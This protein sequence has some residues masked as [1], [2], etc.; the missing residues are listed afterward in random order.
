MSHTRKKDNRIEALH[1]GDVY[2]NEVS[3][4]FSVNLNPLEIPDQVK[5][6]CLHALSELRRY[7]DPHHHDL[8][9]AIADMDGVSMDAVICGNGA[10]ELIMAAVHAVRPS[11]ALLTAPC[12]AGY[13]VALEASGTEIIEHSLDEAN[14]FDLTDSIL[15]DL[16]DD[17][18]MVFL[19]NPNN[20]SGRLIDEPLMENIKKTC[21]EKD[22]CLVTDECFLPLTLH[23]AKTPDP[24]DRSI[25]LRA[26]TKTFAMPALRLGYLICNDG[27]LL[28]KIRRQLPEWNVSLIAERA[29]LAAANMAVDPSGFM[30]KSVK[31]IEEERAY[32]NEE[33]TKLG[34]K[35][36]P[37]DT[38]FILLR[39][40]TDL[41]DRLLEKGIMIR[42]CAN[43]SGL[44]ETFFRIAVRDHRDNTLLIDTLKGLQV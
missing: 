14:A 29:G 2:R 15:G 7:P 44:D 39:S 12:Y 11:K 37:S 19:G 40:R 28:S 34:I 5:I 20:P 6:E 27:E 9:K 4:D 1:G 8:R 10:S 17:L 13:R 42:R 23:G 26:F 21:R 31:L 36:C 25:H 32:L 41:Y 33:L 3:L 24:D 38:N 18:D 35:T 16:T 22:I 30:L 43:F